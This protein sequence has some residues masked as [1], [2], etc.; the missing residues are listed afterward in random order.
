MPVS[1][2]NQCVKCDAPFSTAQSFSAHALAYSA[3]GQ[4]GSNC[5]PV[6]DSAIA[7]PSSYSVVMPPFTAALR[8]SSVDAPANASSRTF[9]VIVSE[10]SNPWVSGVSGLFTRE[11]YRRV[12]AH[13]AEGGLLVQWFQLYEIDPSLVDSPLIFPDAEMFAKTFAFT[14][15]DEKTRERYNKEFNQV[16]GA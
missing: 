14:T 10:P 2:W 9:D 8:I 1:G 7:Q 16:I 3:A 5:S 11:F 12:S 6:S 4:N 15:K 13:L